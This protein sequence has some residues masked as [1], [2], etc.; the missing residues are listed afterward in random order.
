[1]VIL[2]FKCLLYLCT[3]WEDIMYVRMFVVRTVQRD[4]TYLHEYIANKSVAF[5]NWHEVVIVV[6]VEWNNGTHFNEYVIC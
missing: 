1:M 5:W 2:T 4:P 3:S 6:L